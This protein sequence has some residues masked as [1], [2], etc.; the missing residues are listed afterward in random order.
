MIEILLSTGW[1]PH[2][3]GLAA[4][5]PRQNPLAGV[6][7]GKIYVFG[8]TDPSGV[9][10]GD[11]QCYDPEN[12]IWVTKATG[13]VPRRD[14]YGGVFD[15]KLYIHGGYNVTY[16]GPLKD[17]W[18]YDPTTDTW[19]Q[20]LS[21]SVGRLNG[22]SGMLSNGK[23]VVSSGV[24]GGNYS[25]I[26]LLYDVVNNSWSQA[27]SFSQAGRQYG[28]GVADGRKFYCYS[29]LGGAGYPNDFLCYDSTNNSWATLTPPPVGVNIHGSKLFV[30]EGKICIH[31][32]MGSDRLSR[33]DPINNTWS[34][35]KI[36]QTLGLHYAQPIGDKLYLGAGAV[37]PTGTI[38]TSAWMLPLN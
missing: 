34:S 14:C 30:H 1:K 2:A 7:D 23:L 37:S 26:T 3:A 22:A 15:G 10:L 31:G 12:N 11:L 8:G 24:V 5:S 13:P 38:N 20:K 6:I 25:N 28:G 29:G 9:L 18:C 27:A 33:Y 35:A 16:G 4:I 36:D 19:T 32:G 21:S 17:T